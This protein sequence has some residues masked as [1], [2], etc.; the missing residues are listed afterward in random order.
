MEPLVPADVDLRDFGFMPLDVR[1]LLSSETWIEAADEPKV[2]HAVLCLWA[3]SWHQVPASSLPDNDRV[4]AR[5]AM[6]DAREWKTLKD[7]ILAGWVKCSDGLLYHPV[8][9]EKALESW[10]AKCSQRARTKAATEAR[11]A[12]RRS[13]QSQ[14]DEQRN[15]ERDE[16]RNVERDVHQGTVKGQGQ[17]RDIEDQEQSSLRSD[18]SPQLTLDGD[19]TST[20]TTAPA[21]LSARKAARLVQIAADAQA[22]YNR[23]LGKPNGLLTAC[24]VLNKPRCKAVEKA[25]PTAKLLCKALYGSERVVPQFWEDYF[26]E[27]KTDDF[28][29]GRGPYRPPHENWRPDFEYLLREEVMAKLFDR[30]QSAD[31]AGAAA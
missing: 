14:R 16:R 22:A 12:R 4:L 29:A 25:I 10:K 31:A 7:K 11:E 30:A 19:Q 23:I 6:C 21:D 8:V 2:G 28:H 26:T 24:T 13:E 5:L 15:V 18:V 1:R 17:G 27:A 20:T 9:A 3:E